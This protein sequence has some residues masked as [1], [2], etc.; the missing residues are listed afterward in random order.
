VLPLIAAF[1]WFDLIEERLGFNKNKRTMDEI[2]K[3][4]KERI[5]KALEKDKNF[6]VRR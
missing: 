1:L 5:K 4:K 2:D 6:R 3:A